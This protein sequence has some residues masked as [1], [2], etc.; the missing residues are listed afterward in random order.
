MKSVSKLVI[1]QWVF[2]ALCGVGVLANGFHF[3]SIFLVVGAILFIPL[4]IIRNFLKEKVKINSLLSIVIA[5]VLFVAG[6]CFSPSAVSSE[7][8]DG[9]SSTVSSMVNSSN[10][11]EDKSSSTTTSSQSNTSNSSTSSK[12]TSSS[13]TET[14]S[15]TTTSSNPN[16]EMVWVPKTGS[17]YHSRSDCSNMNNPTQ[18]TKAEAEKQGK[19][20]CK[21]CIK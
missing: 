16:S 21:I 6:I 10:Y 12:E 11:S 1:A 9:T 13:K 17:R 20:P 8:Q 2:A 4:P 7:D 14:N 19:T 5:A 15:P 3:S 18:M